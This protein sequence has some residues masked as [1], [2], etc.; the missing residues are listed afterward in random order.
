MIV[1]IVKRSQGAYVGI[2]AFI[3]KKKI[4]IKIIK[5][6]LD[7]DHQMLCGSMLELSQNA[8]MITKGTKVS[9]Y[10]FHKWHKLSQK[11]H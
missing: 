4:G 1:W 9:C 10:N 3:G 5:I 11:A 2:L 6:K 8:Q 7:S